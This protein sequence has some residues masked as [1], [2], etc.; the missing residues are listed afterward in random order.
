LGAGRVSLPILGLIAPVGEGRIVVPLGLRDQIPELIIGEIDQKERT[1]GH[2]AQWLLFRCPL[3]IGPRILRVLNA[4]E[5]KLGIKLPGDHH[6]SGRADIHQGYFRSE[7]PDSGADGSAVRYI[8][9]KLSLR[10]MLLLVKTSGPQQT[11]GESF[12]ESR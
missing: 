11:D 12:D 10:V 7:V 1:V 9:R 6:P 4:A 5:R 2:R 8:R 3:E